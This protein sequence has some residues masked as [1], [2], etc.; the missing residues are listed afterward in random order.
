MR[1]SRPLRQQDD[2]G[3]EVGPPAR[4]AGVVMVVVLVGQYHDGRR[5]HY[6]V[7]WWT[8][9]YAVLL[10]VGAYAAGLPDL[11][12]SPRSAISACVGA[13][14]TGAVGISAAQLVTGSQLLPRF[15]VLTSAV[16]LVPWF[17]A[18]SVVANGGR[19]QERYHDRVLLVAGDEEA[20]ALRDE[21]ACALEHDAHLSL[22]LAPDVARPVA[23]WDEPLV[24]RAITCGATVVVLDRVASADPTIVA[25]AATLHE[26][27]LRVRTLAL[28]YEEW[29]GK[30]P[31]SE[32]ERISLMFDIGELHRARYG[33]TKRVADVAV[34]LVGCVVLVPVLAAVWLV[35]QAGNRGPLL[36]R[37]PRVGRGRTTFTIVKLRTMSAAEGP[38]ADRRARPEDHAR[39]SL[40]APHP[41][42][43][44]AAGVEHPSGRPV[45]GGSL[46]PSSPATSR[47]WP[48][49]CRGTTSATSC[50]RA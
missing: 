8:V 1:T 4:A 47:S 23:L 28:F 5:G 30:L 26:S 6:D 7:S 44:A 45:P 18:C 22:V 24:D 37:Q 35:N 25:Q 48:R 40:A 39:R 11:T 20:A 50:G 16:L 14:A 21:L 46:G 32:L 29:L 9:A 31:V 19:K 42:R 10:G 2:A 13:T 49:S 12:R 43:R 38:T 27:G 17:L 41:P 33:R 3:E 36:Y 34:G 15:V